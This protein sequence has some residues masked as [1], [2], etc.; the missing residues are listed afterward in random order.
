MT[1]SEAFLFMQDNADS[2][3]TWDTG[4]NSLRLSNLIVQPALL[5][6]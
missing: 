6:I 3:N 4:L 5:C 1:F 2:N